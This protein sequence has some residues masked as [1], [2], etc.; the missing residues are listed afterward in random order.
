M[1]VSNG[2]ALTGVPDATTK[3][4]AEFQIDYMKTATFTGVA[5]GRAADVGAGQPQPAGRDGGARRHRRR[6]Q[7][8]RDDA[9]GRGAGRGDHGRRGHRRSPAASGRGCSAAA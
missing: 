8:S 3:L 5:P 4:P 2:D 6:A 7:G 9:G 1:V